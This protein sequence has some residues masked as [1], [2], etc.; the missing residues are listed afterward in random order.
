MRCHSVPVCR[1]VLS[2]ELFLH[3]HSSLRCRCLAPKELAETLGVAVP[4][5]DMLAQLLESRCAGMARAATAVPATTTVAPAQI[6]PPRMAHST[7][8]GGGSTRQ[9]GVDSQSSSSEEEEEEERG[10]YHRRPPPG[11]RHSHSRCAAHKAAVPKVCT[12]SSASTPSRLFA[13]LQY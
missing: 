13:L 1:R 11:P 6:A 9:G 8:S 4:T 5:L 2:N 10:E 3:G 12:A 7:S